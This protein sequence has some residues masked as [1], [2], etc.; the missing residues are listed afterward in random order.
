MQSLK[1]QNRRIAMLLGSALLASSVVAAAAANADE[2]VYYT[3]GG[4]DDPSFRVPY[5]EKYG[6]GPEFVFYGHPDEAF[7]KLQGGFVADVAHPCMHD[8]QKWKDAGLIQPIDPSMVSTWDDL[9]PA[10]RDSDGIVLDGEHWLVPWEWGSSSIIYRND[11]VT[12]SEQSFAMLT[13]PA[14]KGR[15]AVP[16]AFDEIYQVAALLA[17][18]GDPLNLQEDEYAAVEVQ[19]RAIHDNL[20]FIWADPTQLEQAMAAGEVEVAWGWPNSFANLKSQGVPVTWMSAPVEGPVTWMCGLAYLSGSTAP[21]EQV[22]DFIN[23][24]T[25]PESGKALLENFGYGHSNAKALAMVDPALLDSLG[26]G[27]D[28]AEYLANSNFLGAMPVDQ[29]QRLIEMWEA[30]KAGG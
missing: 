15:V 7:T 11:L 23:A 18:V 17:G 26:I 14:Y 4:Y 19:M 24:L 3:W 29:R 13:D 30:V 12:P 25:A 22:Y 8:I 28:P 1:K 5:T 2:L 20:R 10:L 6:D 16:D 27:G 21:K 9:V